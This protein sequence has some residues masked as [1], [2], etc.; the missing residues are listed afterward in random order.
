VTWKFSFCYFH[1]D[2]FIPLL[3]Q[4]AFFKLNFKTELFEKIAQN[5][6][7]GFETTF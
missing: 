4:G 6:I 3:Y 7:F 5:Q 2:D 1:S